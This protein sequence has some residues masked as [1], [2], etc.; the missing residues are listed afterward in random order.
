MAY[1]N[2]NEERYFGDDHVDKVVQVNLKLQNLL[3]S[4]FADTDGIYN[5]VVT[6]SLDQYAEIK[7]RERVASLCYDNYLDAISCSHSI[8][9]MDKEVDL[10]LAKIPQGGLILDVGG[11]WGWHWR[12]LAKTRPDVGVLI[13]DL[14]RSKLPHARNVL[15][16]LVGHQVELMHAD[17]T[18]LPFALSPSFQGFD[19]VW[20]VQTFQ[21]I[22]AYGNAAAE[23]FRVLNSGGQFANYSLNVQ[24]HIRAVKRMLGKDY[25]TA[26][27]IDGSFWLAR[28]SLKQ[29]QQIESIF[30]NAVS[31][32]WSEI[33]FSPELHFIAIGKEGS[34]LGKLDA[35]LSNKVGFFGCFAS[36][37]SFHCQK[38]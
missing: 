16:D 7:L 36:Q 25:T 15:G 6:A 9:V 8:P 12:R 10:F 27:W 17:A 26:G 37:R 22:P 33:L 23:A 24:T 14:V 19:G 21:H 35:L 13:V 28:A 11:C 18:A 1:Q 20:T 5:G 3:S 34:W 2:F 38:S 29:K 30:G 32:R 4:Q 31:E